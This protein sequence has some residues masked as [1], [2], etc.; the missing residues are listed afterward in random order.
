MIGLLANRGSRFSDI[1]LDGSATSQMTSWGKRRSGHSP[2][3]ASPNS[4]A[5]FARTAGRDGG[6]GGP[7]FDD[8]EE[9]GVDRRGKRTPSEG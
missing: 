6:Q 5:G 3:V 1:E 4:G 9:I 7:I 8:Q 2:A